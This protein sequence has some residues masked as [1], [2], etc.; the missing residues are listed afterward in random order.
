MPGL[1]TLTT[2]SVP[3]AVTTPRAMALPGTMSTT[4]RTSSAANTFA[5]RAIKRPPRTA[6]AAAVSVRS[7][8]R[9]TVP[10]TQTRCRP[11]S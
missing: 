3:R 6:A 1:W 7:A 2:V 9:I 8:C 10:T 5:P 11:P 4:S